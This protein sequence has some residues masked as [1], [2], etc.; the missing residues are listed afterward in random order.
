[1]S[2]M[3]ESALDLSAETREE[4]VG[5]LNELLSE[6]IDVQ[7][8]AKQAH[9]NVRSPHFQMLHTLFDGVAEVAMQYVDELAERATTLGGVAEGVLQVVTERS[10]LSRYPLDV[11][12]GEAHL[13]QLLGSVG[14]FGRHVRAAIPRAT[15]AGDD[16][17]A[18]L[19]TELSRAIDKQHW[20]LEAHIQGTR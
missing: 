3:H 12:G 1:M 13:R 8:Q 15:Q 18:D 11:T 10:R 14:L 20:L 17:T 16:G 4:M 9:W 2:R 19:C 6:A 5:L 7:L